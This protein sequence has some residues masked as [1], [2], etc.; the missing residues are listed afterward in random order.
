MVTQTTIFE[1]GLNKINETNLEETARTINGPVLA[2]NMSFSDFLFGLPDNTP[3]DYWKKG[4]IQDVRF[5]GK[6]ELYLSTLWYVLA[7][8]GIVGLILYMSVIFSAVRRNKQVLT[9][10]LVLFVSMFSSNMYIGP[11]F[12][13]YFTFMYLLKYRK[14][15]EDGYKA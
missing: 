13:F 4:K 3:T 10:V 1:A 6:D 7:K 14:S 15:L 9:L 11:Q 5:V 8:L 2:E 12:V